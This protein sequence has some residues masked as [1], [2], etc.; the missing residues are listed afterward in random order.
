MAANLIWMDLEMTGLDPE[1]DLII[2]MATIVTDSE[3]NVLAEGPVLAI[4]VPEERL[5]SMDEWNQTRG[6]GQRPAVRQHNLAG[7][8]LSGPL[9]EDPGGIS[10]LP[11]H[12][13]QQLEG[14]GQSL[15][16]GAAE[17]FH[18]AEHPHRPVRHPR[19]HQGITLLPPVH[20]NPRRTEP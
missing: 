7:S 9:H 12:R 15:A 20:G 1:T 4:A 16:A 8:A 18:Q 10:A 19:I 3:L 6:E 14:A 13:C 17:R 2:E 11:D 5:A